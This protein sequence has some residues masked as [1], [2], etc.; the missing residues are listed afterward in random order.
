VQADLFKDPPVA[1]PL[2]GLVVKLDREIDRKFPCC[3]NF[4]TIAAGKAMH[5]GA[6]LCSGCNRH[7]GWLSKETAGQLLETMRLF[8]PL[9]EKPVI[10][11]KSKSWEGP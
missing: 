5:A 11:D 2:E 3:N 6:L 1:T 10:R 9:T 8:G 7:R 4:A